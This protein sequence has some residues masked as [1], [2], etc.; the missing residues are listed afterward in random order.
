MTYR[1]LSA[2]ERQIIAQR[3]AAGD[4]RSQIAR[5]L[6]RSHSTIGRELERNGQ[7][8][9][10]DPYQAE[11]QASERRGQARHY[12][13]RSHVPLWEQVHQWF[14]LDWSPE[15]IAA[16]L[17]QHYPDDP[18][19]RLSPEALYQWVYRDAREGGSW[20][21]HLWRRRAKRRSH[22]KYRH[23]RFTVPN[24][25]GIAERPKVVEQRTRVGDWEGDSV[26]GKQ[27]KEGLVTHV[28]RA[29]RFLALGRSPD[30]SAS[31]FRQATEQALQWV[32]TGLCNTLTL[33][34]G[35][36]M[37]EHQQI[38]E[39]LGM[40][41][42]FADP[43]SPWQ[44]GTNEQTNGLLRRY[45]PKGTD[46]SKVSDQALNEVVLKINQRP[47]KCLGYQAPYDVF[48]EALRCALA[49]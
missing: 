1:H 17:Q 14:V 24:R 28:D 46:F 48:A 9:L 49:T 4:G 18:Q 6:G 15:I 37:A 21:Q 29:S 23:L 30:R 43:Y 45:F 26:H 7:H 39:T 31:A 32:P 41:T 8:G 20:H 3:R 22:G 2:A 11:Q 5:L 35:T 44:R 13:R 12:R 47:R 27:G 36:E 38:G 19:M 42:Y 40:K 16:K 33:D 34:N 10:Y 25:V